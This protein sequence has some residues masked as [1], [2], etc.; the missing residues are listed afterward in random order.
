MRLSRVATNRS[1]ASRTESMTPGAWWSGIGGMSQ[2][3]TMRILNRSRA[4]NRCT[5]GSL[6][7][8]GGVRAFDRLGELL[9]PLGF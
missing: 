1:F 2:F 9:V 7:G 4:W 6:L 3:R 5:G 8:G